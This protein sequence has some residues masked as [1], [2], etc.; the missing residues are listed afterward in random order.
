MVRSG[1]PRSRHRAI[2]G[3]AAGIAG[4]AVVTLL[5][6]VAER[7]VPVRSAGVIY[8][9]LVLL[10]ATYGG[11]AA[12]L[13]TAVASVAAFNFFL[14]PPLY[15]FKLESGSDWIVLAVFLAA[16]LIVSRLATRAE[17]R[18]VEAE[19]QAEEIR[20]TARSTRRLAAG[21]ELE[22]IIDEFSRSLAVALGAGGGRIVRSEPPASEALAIAL[23][24][25][26]RAPEWWVLDDPPESLDRAAL[27]RAANALG[28]VLQL[29]AQRDA[30]IRE[31]VEV[32]A[33]RES[34]ALKTA[35]LRSV[36]HDL[37]SPLVAIQAAAGALRLVDASADHAADADLVDS[38][39]ES[40]Q[41]LDRVVGDLL[42]LSRLEARGFQPRRD[43]CDAND[44]VAAASHEV[45]RHS[46]RAVEFVPGRGVPLVRVDAQQIQR[47][48]VNLV[49][50]GVK[51]SPPERP[52]R[53]SVEPGERAVRVVVTDAGP[54]IDPGDRPR[55]FEPFYRGRRGTAGVG[56]SGLGL[57][58]AR[59]LA[60]ANGAR[61][62]IDG[63]SGG[64]SVF[65]LELPVGS[66][67][68]V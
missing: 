4:V 51:F 34:D 23:D 21:D 8:L 66:S 54:G 62:D 14:L 57:A 6:A 61:I 35:L 43:W 12:S 24:G 19:R 63:R 67:A 11:L 65:T 1:I 36:S 32:S 9:V 42:D 20:M 47:V 2:S 10:L 55:V 52:V 15:T 17:S 46:G 48:I 5:L 60:E 3:C 41:R 13:V 7:Y 49:E 30:A 26:S 27:D 50:N 28:V 56:G 22:A 37:R 40:A 38:I 59:G 18:R 45:E 64:G 58:V 25:G 68:R 29:G 16:A 53:V 39:L 31:T 44:L 33:L